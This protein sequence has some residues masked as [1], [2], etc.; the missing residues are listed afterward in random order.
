MKVL[1]KTKTTTKIPDCQSVNITE[2]VLEFMT[3][4]V[5][6]FFVS[7]PPCYMY[8]VFAAGKL[9]CASQSE[10]FKITF[11]GLPFARG[12]AA[13]SGKAGDASNGLSGRR[14]RRQRAG[15]RR[16]WTARARGD[17]EA[18]GDWTA[19]AGWRVTRGR[20][21]TGAARSFRADEA[22]ALRFTLR[23]SARV[24][25]RA[26]ADWPRREQE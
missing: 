21:E 1:M 7:Y 8:H 24:S 12:A 14:R 10:R 15:G 22:A 11:W 6:P 17:S 3:I 26:D 5:A 16:R 13:R 20:Q 23:G 9:N 18:V 2:Q 4:P 25:A 19:G